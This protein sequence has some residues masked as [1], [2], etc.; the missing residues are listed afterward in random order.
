MY[1][2]WASITADVKHADILFNISISRLRCVRGIFND[3]F[4]ANFLDSVSVKK[5][6]IGQLT[7]IWTR[8]WR[9]FLIDSWCI[10]MC[11]F[12]TWQ[13][14]EQ[15]LVIL[16]ALVNVTRLL[17]YLLFM[18]R[19][20]FLVCVS[21]LIT[22]YIICCLDTGHNFRHRGYSYQLV[23]YNFSPTRRCFIVRMLFDTL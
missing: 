3:H 22:V 4:I 21:G 12:I 11:T 5:I 8:V 1:T 2:G 7:K 13:P 18:M 23:S 20:C 15:L 17:I 16:Y 10:T 6:K 9:Q 19:N 14:A